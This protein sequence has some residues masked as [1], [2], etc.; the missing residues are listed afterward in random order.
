[1]EDQGIDGRAVLKS[2]KVEGREV[3]LIMKFKKG[4]IEE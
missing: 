1:L 3:N 4:S 2:L